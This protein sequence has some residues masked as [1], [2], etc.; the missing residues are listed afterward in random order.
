M[1][2]CI[3]KRHFQFSYQV[4][5]RVK[6]GREISGWDAFLVSRLKISHPKTGGRDG[7][8]GLRWSQ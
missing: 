2:T 4:K 3:S 6:V 5:A 8:A 1:I 7:V